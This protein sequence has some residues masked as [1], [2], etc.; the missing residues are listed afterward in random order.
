MPNGKLEG[1]NILVATL[2][3]LLESSSDFPVAVRRRNDGTW[4]KF[5]SKQLS[6]LLRPFADKLVTV[7]RHK[8]EFTIFMGPSYEGG[9][10][11]VRE[12]SPVYYRFLALFDFMNHEDW[13]HEMFATPRASTREDAP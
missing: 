1:H 13:L 10:I 4:E 5:G 2:L 11:R 9:W 7:D 6:E 12:D 3:A 8:R